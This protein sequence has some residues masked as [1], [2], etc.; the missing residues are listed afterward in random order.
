MG[1]R[2]VQSDPDSW[3]RPGHCRMEADPP[4]EV[5]QSVWLARYLML[6]LCCQFAVCRVLLQTYFKKMFCIVL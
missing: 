2:D 4:P 1:V 5:F 3:E 6:P